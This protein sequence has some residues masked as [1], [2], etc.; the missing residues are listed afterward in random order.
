ME[1]IWALKQQHSQMQLIQTF[2][3]KFLHLAHSPLSK[4]RPISLKLIKKTFLQKGY[5]KS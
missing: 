1:Q 4:F 3:Y 2:L 5:L